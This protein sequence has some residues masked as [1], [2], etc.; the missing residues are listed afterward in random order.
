MGRAYADFASADF[1]RVLPQV[2]TL[3]GVRMSIAA[4]RCTQWNLSVNHWIGVVS[5]VSI[6]DSQW[7]VQACLTRACR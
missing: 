2:S 3:S 5:I 6:V 7:A 4:G 1:H